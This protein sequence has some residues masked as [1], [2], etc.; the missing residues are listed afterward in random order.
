MSKPS[1]NAEQPD[2]SKLNIYQKLHGIGSD[3][4][5][6]AKGIKTVQGQYKYVSHDAVTAALKPHLN[7]WRLV[8]LPSL[9][10]AITNGDRTEVVLSVK[11]VNI[12][13][14]TET[15]TVEGLGYGVDKSD[16]G[17]G[18]GVSYAFKYIVLKLFALE[19]TDD[20]DH[21]QGTVHTPGPVTAVKT[22][23]TPAAPAGMP[24]QQQSPGGFPSF[25]RGK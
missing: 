10:S 21:D 16:K 7:K 6:V 23:T 4:N 15:E 3:W 9:V 22:K 12:D 8:L 2:I 11:I 14:P 18:K 25:Q 1:E 5:S 24:F 19:T 17:P 20:P 13:N